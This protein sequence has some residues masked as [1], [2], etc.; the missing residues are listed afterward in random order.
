MKKEREFVKKKR[1]KRIGR[2]T[3]SYQK[4]FIFRNEICMY[5]Q[6][7]AGTYL[8]FTFQ[9][10]YRIVSDQKFLILFLY[11]REIVIELMFIS[12]CENIQLDFV[13]SICGICGLRAKKLLYVRDR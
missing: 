9:C 7:P 10:P 2:D 1:E 5:Y 6:L 8:H 11:C 4:S 12:F 13:W 3:N